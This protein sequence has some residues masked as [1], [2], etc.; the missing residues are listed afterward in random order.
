[1]ID[2]GHMV[3]WSRVAYEVRK[4]G[5]SR[6]CSAEGLVVDVTGPG[7]ILPQPQ[8]LIGSSLTAGPTTSSADRARSAQGTASPA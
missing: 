1:M 4:V 3:G 7:R 2:T 8:A 6:P 5:G